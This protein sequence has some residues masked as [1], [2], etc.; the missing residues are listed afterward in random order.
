MKIICTDNFNQET[1]ADRLVAKDIINESEADTMCQAL[2][3]KYS[4]EMAH[5]W[6]RVVP[7]DY[8]LSLG[9]EDLV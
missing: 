2:N 7:D 6:F 4:G 9:M 1:I 5:D 3:D 8:R